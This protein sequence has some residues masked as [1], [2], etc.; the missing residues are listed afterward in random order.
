MRNPLKIY[1]TFR[2]T[3]RNGEKKNFGEQRGRGAKGERAHHFDMYSGKLHIF[4]MDF[5]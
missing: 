1:V 5:S 3:C 4:S 2:Y